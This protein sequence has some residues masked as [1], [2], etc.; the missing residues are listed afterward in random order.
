MV[1]RIGRKGRIR[2]EAV[3]TLLAEQLRRHGLS[4]KAERRSQEGTPDVRIELRSGDLLLLECKWEGS[5]GL[6]DDQTR[7]RLDQF[8]EALGIL[9]IVY[10]DCLQVA[11][12]IHAD[13]GGAGDLRWRLY[14]SRGAIVA[15]MPERSVSVEDL[16]AQLRYLPLELEGGDRVDAAAAIVGYAVNKAVEPVRQHQRLARRIS[17]IIAEADKESDRLAALRIGCL[18]LFNALAF[19]D[20]LA[21]L[22]PDVPDSSG[23]P[24]RGPGGYA[25]GM[26]VHLRRY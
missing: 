13:L 3:N 6:L 10:P 14:G 5:A 22:H 25:A 12:D 8:P 2:E 16:A 20:R 21:A 24:P 7:Q 9:G 4:A 26:A 17:D 11:E 15:D 1:A 18:V 19:Q 23:G